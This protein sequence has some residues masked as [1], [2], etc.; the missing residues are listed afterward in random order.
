M[1]K[2]YERF[3]EKA[4]DKW[5]NWFG[6][7]EVMVQVLDSGIKKTYSNKFKIKVKQVNDENTNKHM[8]KDVKLI[9]GG[10]E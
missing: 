7:T 4:K 9:E 2:A 6:E 5:G 8:I 3:L 10:K 1:S